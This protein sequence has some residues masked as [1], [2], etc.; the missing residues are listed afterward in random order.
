L[1]PLQFFFPDTVEK[2][3]LGVVEMSDPS[4]Q[5]VSCDPTDPLCEEPP[6]CDPTDPLC[7]EPPG[8]D[9]TDPL[10][11]EPPGCDPED[12]F[13]GELP[14]DET[15]NCEDGIDNDGDGL[16]DGDDLECSTGGGPPL[17]PERGNCQDG[18][19]N[20]QDGRTDDDDSDCGG[21]SGGPSS[22][23]GPGNQLARGGNDENEITINTFNAGDDSFLPEA[24]AQLVQV[25]EGQI[26]GDIYYVLIENVNN[27]TKFVPDKVTLSSGFTIVWINNDISQ[28]HGIVVTNQ[29][30]EQLLNS[31]VSY[32]NFIDYKFGSEGTFFYSESENGKSDG[33]VTIVSAGEDNVEISEPLPGIEII[34][35]ALGFN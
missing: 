32:N 26:E 30:G 29:N 8:C 14:P 25:A 2:E 24:I 28:D 16:T 13:C 18:I 5:I 15:G 21:G 34:I 1:T 11:E 35:S 23:T 6:G 20:D 7:E 22:T 17:S 19:D 31:V 27:E 3:N 9:P 12:P 4:I 33:I 10:C